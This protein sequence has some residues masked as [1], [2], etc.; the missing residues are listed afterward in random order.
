MTRKLLT[1]LCVV[2]MMI[3]VLNAQNTDP[4]IAVV[5]HRGYW[6][7]DEGGYAKNSLAAL[8]AAQKAGF[9]GSE[10][11]VNMTADGVLVVFHD[12]K[13]GG[14]SIENNNFEAFKDVRLSNGESLP[15]VDDFLRQAQK[16][17]DVMMVY[18][19]KKHSCNEVEDRFVDLTIE[20]LRE[21]SMDDPSKV[22]FI[23]FS[24]HICKS[25]A[26]K[27]PGF[28]VQYLGS[29]KS[30]D[31]LS[32]DGI[33]GLDYHHLMLGLHKNWIKKAHSLGLEVNVWTVNKEDQ[34]RKMAKAGVDMITTDYPS[35]L[36]SILKELD[37]TEL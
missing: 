24:Y 5:A 15:T 33:N 1:F 31:K 20:K 9:W 36:Q 14:V 16:Y 4:E 30:P 3:N 28:K 25:L 29:D 27:M 2:L 8:E 23:S 6:N 13:I 12:G 26:K 22:M 18:E 7:C 19:L 35:T 37:I 17:P 11:D 10:F 21:Y 32:K 34:M